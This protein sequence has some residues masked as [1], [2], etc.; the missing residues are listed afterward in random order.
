MSEQGNIRRSTDE[1]AAEARLPAVFGLRAAGRE[2][3]VQSSPHAHKF[4]LVSGL[5][6][7]IALAAV[8]VAVVLIV[9][10]GN[11]GYAG[12]WSPWAPPDSG[13]NG[14][15]EIAD[16]V[17]PYYRLSGVD[18]LAVVTVVNTGNPNDINPTT[19]EPY[20][21]QV[22]VR[23]ELTSSAVSLLPGN[24]IAFNL[25]GVGS[26][27]CKVGVGKASSLRVLLLRREALELALYTF[28][29]IPSTSNVVAILPPGFVTSGCSGICASPHSRTVTT[30]ETLAVLFEKSELQPLLDHPLS[31]ALPNQYPPSISELPTWAETEEAAL[32]AQVTANGLFSERTANAQDG[33]HLIE[34]DPQPPS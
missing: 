11:G 5:L 23:P 16:H 21:L 31:A 10:G 2:R 15:Q 27:N 30:P 9:D 29:Y 26:T 19:G 14:A 25:C 3:G 4:M 17:A 22:A 32:V 18:Q 6:I 8:V 24:T 12:P 33:S 1:H 34:L 13:L 28:K 20:G 7:G